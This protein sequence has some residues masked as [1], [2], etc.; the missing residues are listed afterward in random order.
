MKNRR[1]KQF[2]LSLSIVLSLFASSVSAACACSHHGQMSAENHVASCHQMTMNEPETEQVSG[3]D[4]MPHVDIGCHCFIKTAQPF[5][6]GKSETVKSQKNLAVLPLVSKTEKTSVVA[7][8]API[9]S[10]F[11]RHFY[12]SNYL[13]KLLPARA[14]PIS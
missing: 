7:K 10:H 13:R 11:E 12:N 1:L 4:E 5:V 14:P 6:V 9:K 2:I 3:S 8:I